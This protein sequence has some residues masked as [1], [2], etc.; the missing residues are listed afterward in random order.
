MSVELCVPS[1][2]SACDGVYGFWVDGE[3]PPLS[4]FFCAH[5]AKQT[6]SAKHNK[7]D[8]IFLNPFLIVI[9][10]HLAYVDGIF[11]YRKITAVVGYDVAHRIF[12]GDRRYKAVVILVGQICG[13]P[14]G[15]YKNTRYRISYVV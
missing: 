7:A 12:A 2:C 8:M 15:H 6:G 5:P 3:A 13:R 4:M 1:A 9:L 11:I 10:L 14:I